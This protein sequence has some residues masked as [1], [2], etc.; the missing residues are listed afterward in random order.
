MRVSVIGLG[1]LGSPL[2]AVIAHKGHT[3][4]GADLSPELVRQVNEGKAPTEEPGLQEMI[5]GCRSRLSA[6]TDTKSAVEQTDLTH[7][8]V[9]TPSGPD[10]TFSLK[11]VLDAVASIGAGLREKTAFH[12]VS[13]T[14]T[15]MP[16]H[17]ASQVLP[18][19][20]EASG[21]RCGTDF[22]LCYNPEFIAL[23]N[24]IHGLIH[25]DFLLI[26]ESDSRSGQVLEDFYGTIC[27]SKPPAA[28]MTFVNAELTKLSVNTFVTTKISYANMLSQVCEGLPGADVDVV[29]S[30]LGLDTRIGGK[31]LRG[32]LGYG[33]PCFP[34][35]NVAFSA[36]AREIGSPATLVEATDSLNREQVG[37]LQRLVMSHLPT[38]GTVG[39]LGLSYKPDTPVVEESQGLELAR[40]LVDAG[41]RVQAYDPAAVGPARA[42]LGEEVTFT[43]SMIDC[44][45]SADVLVL[46]TPW[47][48]FR[49]LDPASIKAGATV[50]DCW[51]LLPSERFATR[52]RHVVLG[53]G[54]S[55]SRPGSVLTTPSPTGHPG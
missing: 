43:V 21:R 9:P 49:Q 34:R 45:R 22:G 38:G 14:S 8:I 54:P 18:A 2:A 28:R 5:D 16:G 42:I 55:L 27:E 39:V 11:Y 53:K 17:T 41:T 25:P 50:I 40:R 3:V 4:V 13:L 7:L 47:E 6:T 51:R 1:K 36:L 52:A 20:E 24:V 37:R 32:A 15:V 23:G 35:D 30:A 31:Y 10:G 19:L 48:E 29:T 12:V 26:G 46:A 44:A 33:G